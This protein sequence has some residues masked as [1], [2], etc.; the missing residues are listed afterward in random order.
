MRLDAGKPPAK[1][2]EQQDAGN[3]SQIDHYETE[4]VALRRISKPVNRR[5]EQPADRLTESGVK[6]HC[7]GMCSDPL[8][9]VE[10]QRDPAERYEEVPKCR[11]C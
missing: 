8:Q 9:D 5:L 10:E 1:R 4:T 7:D 11:A 2:I 6:H 3:P